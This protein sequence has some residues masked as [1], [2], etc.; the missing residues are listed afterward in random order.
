MTSAP[1]TLVA[2]VS[3]M[4]MGGTQR[5][6]SL[7]LS[8]LDRSRWNPCLIC[9][10]PEEPLLAALRGRGVAVRR[11]EKRGRMDPTLVQR[12]ARALRSLKPD[13]VHT[14]L[15]SANLWGRAAAIAAGAPAI[16]AS[17]RSVAYRTAKPI[18]MANRVLGRW[19]ALVTVNSDAGVPYAAFLHGHPP[20][21]IARVPNG[22]VLPPLDA[23]A[24]ARARERMRAEN[25]WPAEARV[26]A[27]VGNL[28][29]DK[30]IG[31]ALAAAARL[32]ERHP[33]LRWIVFG[34][35]PERDALQRAIGAGTGP[36][37]RLTEVFRLAGHHEDL[38]ALLPGA[39]LLVQTSAREGLPNAVL[40]GMAAGLP[41]V[42]TD[43][44]G[45]REAMDPGVTGVL[46]A[47]GDARALDAA[48]ESVLPPGAGQRMGRAGRERAERQFSVEAMIRRSERLYEE[49]CGPGPSPRRV[50]VVLSRHSERA[51]FIVREMRAVREA[52]VDLV[53]FSLL[54]PEALDGRCSA[55]AGEPSGVSY[56]PFL[57]GPLDVLA[58]ARI[59]ALHPVRTLSA[60]GTLVFGQIGS[61]RVMLRTLA[62]FPKI[63]LLA[64]AAKRWR[65]GAIHAH[66]ATVSASAGM[67]A[68]RMAGLPFSFSGHAWDLVF[69]TAL[70]G[71]KLRAARFAA[72]CNRFSGEALRRRYPDSAEKVRLAYHG[73]DLGRFAWR[74]PAI[75]PAAPL[76]VL[77]IGRLVEKKGF[78]DLIRAVG[79]LSRRARGPL[80]PVQVTCRIVGDGGPE[81]ACLRALADAEA[82]GLVRFDPFVE[83]SGVVA[84]LHGHD[85]LAAPSVVQSDGAMDGIPNVVLE[86]MACGLPVVTT[87]VAGI[88][89]VARDGTTA[90]LVPERD[91]EALARALERLGR[92]PELAGRLSRAARALVET[93][94]DLRKTARELAELL[95]GEEDAPLRS[96]GARLPLDRTA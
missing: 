11:V 65:A 9:T 34:E 83:E 19:T 77:A 33:A 52:G 71:R 27:L 38:S 5:Q 21:R 6:I 89:E 92:E 80:P 23:S 53:G 70:L 76:R 22:V 58:A 81:E 79:R 4:N 94:F 78:D 45:T 41:V 67:A 49:R 26:A 91:P 40:E 47:V 90:L 7:L 24:V 87:A 29:P 61:P 57:P 88:P 12:L 28:L 86:A 32:R 96:A 43:A 73:L 37:S 46:V 54:P 18:L 93:E 10:G 72:V 62:V 15:R 55:G 13:V 63:L 39:D 69:D 75:R 1:R 51:T 59:A 25:G 44:G 3:H 31:D 8:G 64:A 48:L 36:G 16:V 17:E 66:W 68:A 14:F 56:L 95:A 2:I 35:G 30:R 42:A 50:A 85:L 60:L 84:L 74:E 20:D 82:P